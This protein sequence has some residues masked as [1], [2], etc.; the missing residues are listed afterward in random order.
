MKNNFYSNLDLK[1][2]VIKN[3]KKWVKER[4]DRQNYINFLKLY[5]E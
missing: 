5:K 1:F 3:I 2:Q 4:R